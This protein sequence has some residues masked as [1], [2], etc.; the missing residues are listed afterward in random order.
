MKKI[1]ILSTLLLLSFVLSAC[2]VNFNSGGSEEEKAD[3]GGVF[4]SIDKGITWKQ[5][6]ALSD[7][8]PGQRGF[9]GTSVDSFK[10][11][12]GDNMALYYG[13]I[14]N[15]LAFTYDGGSSWQMA[16]DLG[17]ISINDLAIDPNSK[18]RVYVAISNKLFKTDDCSRHWKQIYID[19]VA[20]V[21]VSSVA[22]NHFDSKIIYI[23]LSRGDFIQSSD[24]GESWKTIYRF[25]DNV[26]KILIDPRDSRKI[27]AITANKGV[28]RSFD[29][30]L[31]W[32][33]LGGAL[34]EAGIGNNIR[35]MII[36]NTEVTTIYLAG[37]NGIVKSADN[38][39]SFEKIQLITP[40]KKS[41]INSV[42]V[43]EKDQNE[44]YYVTNTTFF[45]SSDG[46][47]NWTPQKLPT[48][49]AGW[50]LLIDPENPN[51]IYMAIKNLQK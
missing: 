15:G 23:G 29:S 19:N 39:D 32:D 25:K 44:I 42:A 37:I 13:S 18:C 40:D 46:G 1:K 4:K 22:V 7:T 34:K 11:D 30:G 47:D 12:P 48:I 45:K 43:N 36:L 16:K 41:Q 6:V 31:S 26:I 27:Y 14:A 49:R 20:A 21:K 24:F 3:I 17:A 35:D 28:F 38:G 33:N 10:M 2:S 9:G 50:K 51:I 8:G 5:K